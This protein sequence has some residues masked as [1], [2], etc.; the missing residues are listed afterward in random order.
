MSSYMMDMR[1]IVGHRPILQCGASVIVMN[2]KDQVL[3]QKR[4]DNHCWGYH[5]G[6]V[7]LDEEVEQAAMRELY[8]ETGLQADALV[9]FGVFSGPELHYVYP[10]G[11]EVSNIDIVYLCTAYHGHLK[12]QEDE[13]E[14]LEWFALDHL[15]DK[16]T[17]PNQPALKRL[18]EMKR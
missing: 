13:V 16:I 18:V 5:G 12:R 2:E 9:L 1:Q 10:N 15:P 7:E 6:S 3:L 14:A 17:P 8:E 11:D 4:M